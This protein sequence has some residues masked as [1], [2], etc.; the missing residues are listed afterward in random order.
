MT[1]HL[2]YDRKAVYFV[3]RWK[4]ALALALFMLIVAVCVTT[5]FIPTR[6]PLSGVTTQERAKF[7]A[8]ERYREREAAALSLLKTSPQE[9]VSALE[10]AVSGARRDGALPLRVPWP[11]QGE[12]TLLRLYEEGTG[13]DALKKRE[14]FSQ[15]FHQAYPNYRSDSGT[16]SVGGERKR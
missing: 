16:T 6:R 14:A 15:Y 7:A 12:I 13:A 4:I 9:G 10:E 1:S 8:F 2:D 5:A 11:S 3:K